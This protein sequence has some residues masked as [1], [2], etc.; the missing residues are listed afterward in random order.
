MYGKI[1]ARNRYDRALADRAFMVMMNARRPIASEELLLLVRVDP[2][3]SAAAPFAS[4]I[5][6]VQLLHLCNNLLLL[7]PASRAW[8]L[9]H[10]SV[11]EYLN[12]KVYPLDEARLKTIRMVGNLFYVASVNS[13]IM[14]RGQLDS[15]SDS[16]AGSRPA[17]LSDISQSPA[18][19]LTGVV[20]VFDA[21]NVD[22]AFEVL[23]KVGRMFVAQ[24][25]YKGA[26]VCL[27]VSPFSRI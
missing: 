25:N 14:S 13:K 23:V 24:D 16:E 20:F 26:Q 7:D 17:Q 5:T 15:G 3:Q 9:S 21:F 2:D 22:V 18:V 4:P 27:P 10:V 12:G 1:Q 11:M 19:D 6:E 8:R